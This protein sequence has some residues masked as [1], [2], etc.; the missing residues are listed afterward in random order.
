MTLGMT[1]DGQARKAVGSY[2]AQ[3]GRIAHHIAVEAMRQ[4]EYAKMLGAL[5]EEIGFDFAISIQSRLK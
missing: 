5:P 3:S 2:I 1:T 4:L